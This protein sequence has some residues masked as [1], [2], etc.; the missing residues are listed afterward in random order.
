MI[1]EKLSPPF[2]AF[3]TKLNPIDIPKTFHESLKSKD[4]RATISEEMRALDQNILREIF[5]L[6]IGKNL[7][8]VSGY[9]TQ[10]TGQMERHK[11]KLVA[12]ECTQIYRI[13][14]SRPLLLW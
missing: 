7:S 4:G 13:Y 6:P 8:D 5:D 10:S 2:K 1:L 9:S 11:P 12:K 14:I 3:V